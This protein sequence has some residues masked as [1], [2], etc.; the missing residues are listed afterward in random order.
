MGHT[1][2]VIAR[3]SVLHNIHNVEMILA[4]AGYR[5]KGEYFHVPNGLKNMGQNMRSIA[6]SRHENKC[7]RLISQV[8]LTEES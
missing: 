2:L 8:L 3:M 6:R 7:G 5:E 1:D 4:D